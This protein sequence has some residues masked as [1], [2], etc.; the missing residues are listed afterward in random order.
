[1]NKKETD[2]A[3]EHSRQEYNPMLYFLTTKSMC[4][5]D[6]HSD[7]PP[8]AVVSR[9]G[10]VKLRMR[11]GFYKN[12]HKEFYMNQF[13]DR[14]LLEFSEFY[15]NSQRQFYKNSQIEPYKN[16]QTEL[17][18]NPQA[19]FYKNPHT[20]EFDKISQTEVYKAD[21]S[22]TRTDQTVFRNC[23]GPIHPKR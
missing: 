13:S 15:Q 23:T 16:P 14:V 9:G 19:E 22:S 18:K 10:I 4:R 1:M 7:P 8:T 21:Q 11:A 6:R 3:D 20:A 17:Y 2:S 12:S 5:T